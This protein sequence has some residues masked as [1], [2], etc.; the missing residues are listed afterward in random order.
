VLEIASNRK[1]KE[2]ILFAD[3]GSWGT[4]EVCRQQLCRSI[5]LKVGESKSSTELA[6]FDYGIE[7]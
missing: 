2:Y 5:F 1:T 6:N 4:Q 7:L 3:I